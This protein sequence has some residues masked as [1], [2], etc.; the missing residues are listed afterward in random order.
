MMLHGNFGLEIF[1]M[2]DVRGLAFEKFEFEERVSHIS[3][4]IFVV[5]FLST[6]TT[7]TT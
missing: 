3:T 4:V 5:V 7:T 1:G 2:E 6:T